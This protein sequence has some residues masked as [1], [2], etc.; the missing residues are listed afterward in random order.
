MVKFGDGNQL[1]RQAK[2]VYS[3]TTGEI[4]CGDCPSPRTPIRTLFE[5]P[6]AANGA[7]YSL[8]WARASRMESLD[9]AIRPLNGVSIS[10]IA[11]T[12][13]AM[14]IEANR[15]ITNVRRLRGAISPR[16]ANTIMSQKTSTR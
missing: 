3:Y 15:I 11:K 6:F 2:R 1:R 16:L 10:M 7:I 12:T 4:L 13:E 8:R 5:L 14:A 9:T